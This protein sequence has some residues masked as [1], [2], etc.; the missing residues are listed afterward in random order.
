VSEKSDRQARRRWLTIAEIVA[1]AGVVIA[2][3]SLWNNW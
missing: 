1:V 2:G 3:L